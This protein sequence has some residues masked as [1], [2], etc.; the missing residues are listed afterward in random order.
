MRETVVRT[1]FVALAIVSTIA[2][3]WRA[4]AQDTD[5]AARQHYQT[6]AD[7]YQSG[8]F[9]HAA[10][11]FEQAYNLSRRPRLLYNAYLAYRDLQDTRNAARTL[12][13]F[14]SEA[15]DLEAE[16][17]TQLEARLAALE[18]AL[19]SAAG[20][21]NPRPLPPPAAPPPPPEEPEE[22]G[23][24]PSP[25]TWV[26]GGVGVALLVGALVT[27]LMSNADFGLLERRCS[28]DMCPDDQ[29]L[30]DAQSSGKTLALVTD[31]LWISGALAL[32]AA[33]VMFFV[34]REP[35]AAPARDVGLMCAPGGC[36]GTFRA[37]F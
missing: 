20:E 30:R 31:V 15:D 8:D 4:R 28:G 7:A 13:Q 34:L 11:E 26:V 10:A 18:R 22:P 36:Y 37:R 32:G 27:G 25:L 21:T 17:R 14:L 1:C 23:S 3:P 12:R 6:G 19:A 24:S 29:E 5:T 35:D 33:T 9:A 16:E 2:V